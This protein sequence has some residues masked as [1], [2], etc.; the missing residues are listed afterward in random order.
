MPAS[1]LI[2]GY[3]VIVT[4]VHVVAAGNEGVPE[5]LEAVAQFLVRIE[6]PYMVI[7][8][9]EIPSFSTK[10]ATHFY[11]SCES[12]GK[13]FRVSNPQETGLAVIQ[14]VGCIE[15]ECVS[16]VE[17]PLPCVVGVCAIGNV[18]FYG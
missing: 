8:V 16:S 15:A 12:E 4:V 13:A 11:A 10:L 2:A 6:F 1:Q 18:P 7:P 17:L 3:V 5:V 9:I 14:R